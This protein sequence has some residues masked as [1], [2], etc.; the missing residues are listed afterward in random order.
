MSAT[1]HPY[2]SDPRWKLL[3]L[4]LGVGDDDG[5]TLTDDT[6][7]ATFGH[8]SVETPLDN[9][10]GSRVTGPHRWY[11][12]V[13]LRLSFSDDGLT[14]GT[15][16]KRGLCIEFDTKVPRVIGLHDHSAL[17]VSVEDPEGLAAALERG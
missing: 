4:P 15:T 3:L 9:V 7:R 17:W 2:A 14:F 6:L 5:V 12:A 10:V 16:P 1:F 11:T 13:G 8:W